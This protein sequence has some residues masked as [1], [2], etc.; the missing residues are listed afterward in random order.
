MG[1]DA[2]AYALIGLKIDAEKL[3]TEKEERACG[4]PIKD[5]TDKFCATCG[6]P[7]QLKKVK[8]P[9]ASY[10]LDGQD[11]NGSVAG[12]RLV[13]QS[14]MEDEPDFIAGLFVA[15]SYNKKF[16][17]AKLSE[18]QVKKIHDDMQAKLE[19]LGLWNESAFGLYTILYESC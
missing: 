13:S 7:L 8:I 9:I 10:K 2:Y 4:H 17:K 3:Y 14:S 1:Y 12:F 11:G 16:T 18:G 5:K 15:T 6:K 19:P